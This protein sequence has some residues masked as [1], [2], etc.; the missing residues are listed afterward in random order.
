MIYFYLFDLL[1]Q[2][3][4]HYI[5]HHGNPTLDMYIRI[6]IA[7][8]GQKWPRMNFNRSDIPT[9]MYQHSVLISLFFHKSIAK[10]LHV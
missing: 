6:F 9:P 3:I 4:T 7:K 2:H 8:T 5:C 10:C 1:R